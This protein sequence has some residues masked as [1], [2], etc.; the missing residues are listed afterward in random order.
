MKIHALRWTGFFLLVAL[1]QGCT[2]VASQ[3]LSPGT[4]FTNVEGNPTVMVTGQSMEVRWL[5]IPIVRMADTT[6][7]ETMMMD[8]VHSAGGSGMH[9]LN[10]SCAEIPIWMIPPYCLFPMPAKAINYTAIGTKT[11]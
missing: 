2:S 11:P 7:L 6:K 8:K 1:V 4:R 5:F 9:I 3:K 10:G